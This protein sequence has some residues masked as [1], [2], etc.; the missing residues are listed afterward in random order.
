MCG[1][2]P[3]HWVAIGGHLEVAQ[4]LI[5][6]GADVNAIDNKGRTQH[7]WA[8]MCGH[9][10]LAKLL[11]IVN[12]LDN[13][14]SIENLTSV[15]MNQKDLIKD[16]YTKNKQKVDSLMQ[17]RAKALIKK[18]ITDLNED[19]SIAI[20]KR[21]ESF[22]K[23]IKTRSLEELCA[24]ELQKHFTKD[25]ND[26]NYKELKTIPEDFQRIIFESYTPLLTLTEDQITFAKNLLN[27]LA[28]P[29]T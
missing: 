10:K 26:P 20:I 25:D 6:N 21:G 5:E 1:D 3:L 17:T 27:K 7:Y 4:I 22:L 2:T 9:L 11:E 18:A 8:V 29:E 23:N 28:A 24:I 19:I 14:D 12:H 15:Y 13:N 16:Y